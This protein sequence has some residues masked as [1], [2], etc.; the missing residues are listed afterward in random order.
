MMEAWVEDL[1]GVTNADDVLIEA[2]TERA[3]MH[4]GGEGRMPA[5]VQNVIEELVPNGRY[6]VVP[7]AGWEDHNT[8]GGT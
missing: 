3:Y 7:W 4:I 6:G 8:T 2:L 1:R 5:C